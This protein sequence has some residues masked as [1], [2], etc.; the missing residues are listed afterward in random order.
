MNQDNDP[1]YKTVTEFFTATQHTQKIHF[2]VNA[3]DEDVKITDCIN[4]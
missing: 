2:H 1:N 4:S 3:F